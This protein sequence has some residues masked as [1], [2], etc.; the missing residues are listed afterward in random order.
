LLQVACLLEGISEVAWVNAFYHLCY[1][2]QFGAVVKASNIGRLF[3]AALRCTTKME[4]DVTW[5]NRVYAQ[6]ARIPLHELNPLELEFLKLM[7]YDIYVSPGDHE[8]IKH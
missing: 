3:L 8:V 4:D 1:L 2:K 6:I 5:S 7:H